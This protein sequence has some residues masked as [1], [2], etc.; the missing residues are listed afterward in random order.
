[1]SVAV[2]RAR[3]REAA[4]LYLLH[5]GHNPPRRILRILWLITEKPL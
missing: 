3:Y 2:H 4:R 5:T 1:M